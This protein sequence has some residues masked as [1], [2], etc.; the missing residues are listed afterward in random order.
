MSE[1][2]GG[3]ILI[4][5]AGAIGGS[6]GASFLRA[7]HEVVFVDNAADHVAAIRAGGLRIE[8]PL[9][10]G[11]VQAP[12]F[13]PSDVQGT[14][15]RVFLCVKALHTRE[16]VKALAPH[17]AEGGYVVSAQNGLNE[18]EIAETVG[19]ERTIGCFVNFGADYLGPGVVHLSG[20]G[21]VVV[22]WDGRSW[23]C[24][25]WRC[26]ARARGGS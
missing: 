21:A 1:A 23:S 25:C 18:I 5:G 17:L 13:L 3:P 20:R 8:G 24:C 10:E 11:V 16:A 26:W 9:W 4:W 22:G 7:G 2:E 12:A 6:L 14:F 19:P 15:E